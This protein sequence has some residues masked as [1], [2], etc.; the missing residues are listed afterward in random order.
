MESRISED[1]SYAEFI[2]DYGVAIL[3]WA[4]QGFMSGRL[5][6]GKFNATLMM[7]EDS[8]AAIQVI[9]KHECEDADNCVCTKFLEEAGLENFQE[10]RRIVG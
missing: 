9:I 4:D 1:K 5:L 3:T 6:C 7:S 2:S 8:S 10:V